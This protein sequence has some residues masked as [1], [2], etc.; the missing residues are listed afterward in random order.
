MRNPYETHDY[1][2]FRKEQLKR[3][4]CA[5]I[6]ADVREAWIMAMYEMS[7]RGRGFYRGTPKL[8]PLRERP[9]A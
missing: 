3:P 7:R 5:A 6:D 9:D 2:R 4:S 8:A 1:H